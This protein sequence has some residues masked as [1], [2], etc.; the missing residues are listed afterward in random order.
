MYNDC[1]F[2]TRR[3]TLKDVAIEMGKGTDNPGSLL[4]NGLL[5]LVL[6][7]TAVASCNKMEFW[8]SGQTAVCG[9]ES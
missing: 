2:G 6:L 7:L 5:F 8:P 4:F 1:D 9:S 3:K